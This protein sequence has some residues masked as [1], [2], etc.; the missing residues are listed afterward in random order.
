MLRHWLRLVNVKNPEF[1][2]LLHQLWRDWQKDLMLAL[3]AGIVVC[4]AFLAGRASVVS[5][6]GK[7]SLEEYAL[8]NAS[9]GLQGDETLPEK[10][11]VLVASKKG[12][13]YHL[14]ECPGAQR[15][16]QENKIYFS[17]KEEAEETGY[18]PAANCPGLLARDEL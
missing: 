15:I 7:P 11:H 4:I 12:R 5:F 6:A 13:K 3:A 8:S 9:L 2:V 17:T 18:Q 10:S 14:P 1:R 16:A